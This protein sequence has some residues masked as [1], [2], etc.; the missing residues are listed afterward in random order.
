MPQV[1]VAVAAAPKGRLGGLASEGVGEGRRPRLDRQPSWGSV[2]RAHRQYSS[3]GSFRE[4]VT[5]LSR[6]VGWRMSARRRASR[7]GVVCG[8]R[9]VRRWTTCGRG[10][11][12]GQAFLRSFRAEAKSSIVL[13]SSL[14][15]P[16]TSEH[17]LLVSSFRA[18]NSHS[19]ASPMVMSG[20]PRTREVDRR[21]RWL[22][23][24]V[25]PRS[26]DAGE[27]RVAHRWRARRL[28]QERA[29]GNGRRYCDQGS[30][31][32]SHGRVTPSDSGQTAVAHPRVRPPC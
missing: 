14:A 13:D 7:H 12:A 5:R 29:Y 15:A 20:R 27:W 31:L 16:A 23:H 18:L 2:P 24:T 8:Q 26:S 11:Y 32:P 3:P 21:L 17:E 6:H 30:R 22:R 1:G 9:V 10:G 4:F 19:S 25:D 28:P